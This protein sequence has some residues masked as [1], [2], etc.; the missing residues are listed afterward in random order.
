MQEEVEMRAVTLMITTTKLS[1]RVVKAAITKLLQET[2]KSVAKHKAK[3]AIPH[4]KQTVKQ[5]VNQGA[6]ASNIETTNLR[7]RS[8]DR[9]ARKFGVDY[10]VQV[11]KSSEVPKYLIFFKGRDADALSAAFKEY[12]AKEINKEA[13]RPSVVA[14]LQKFKSLVMSIKRDPVKTK[15]KGLEL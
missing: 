12:S 9:V 7:I 1:A 2:Q 3:T 10:A 11:D 15:E 14:K 5:L 13:D 8:F 6:G 4:G